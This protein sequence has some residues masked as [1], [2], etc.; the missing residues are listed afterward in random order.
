[1]KMFQC[2]NAII[3]FVYKIKEKTFEEIVRDDTE[4]S[5]NFIVLI[6]LHVYVLVNPFW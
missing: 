1:M 3:K 2:H 6:F 4:T 5:D